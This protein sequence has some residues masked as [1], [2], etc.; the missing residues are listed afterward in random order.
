MQQSMEGGMSNSKSTRM[1]SLGKLSDFGKTKPAQA[2]SQEVPVKADVVASTKKK[3]S[4]TPKKRKTKSSETLTTVNIKIRREQHQ[5]LS[6]TARKVR[7]NNFEPVRP[8]ERVYPQHLIGVAI[9]LLKNYDLK[10]GEIKTVEDLQDQL[11]L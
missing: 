2:S 11:N 7:D 1:G 9:E 5:W 8:N 4:V 3:P 6:D 10:W